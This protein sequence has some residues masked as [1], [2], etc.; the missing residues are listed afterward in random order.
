MSEQPKGWAYVYLRP[1]HQHRE[2]LRDGAVVV[3]AL[4]PPPRE[5]ARPHKR[6]R[7]DE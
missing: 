5:E 6:H 3:L 4:T 2:L 1:T 7:T